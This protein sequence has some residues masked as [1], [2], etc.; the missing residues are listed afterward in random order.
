MSNAQGIIKITS[1]NQL[2]QIL[3]K[4]SKAAMDFNASWCGS[5]KA[6]KPVFDKLSKEHDDVAFLS[7]DTDENSEIAQEYGITSMPTFKFVDGGKV[8]NEVVGANK[9]QLEQTM[10]SFTS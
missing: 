1:R 6:M 3:Q 5:C 8:V 4:N 2:N 10:T 9:N 7:I